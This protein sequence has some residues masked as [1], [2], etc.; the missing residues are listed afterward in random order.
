MSGD[1][2][3]LDGNVA[4]N[5]LIYDVVHSWWGPGPLMVIP[6]MVFLVVLDVVYYMRAKRRNDA[7][8]LQNSLA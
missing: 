1:S 6:W 8:I 3:T 7:R 2:S 5:C 4:Q